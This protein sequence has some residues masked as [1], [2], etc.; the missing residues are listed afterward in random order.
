MVY[1]NEL[2]Q[3][4]RVDGPAIKHANGSQ[5]WWFNGKRHRVGGPAVIYT[6]GIEE[7]YHHGKRHRVDG[8]AM[9]L[10]N[11]SQYWYIND[12]R[13]DEFEHMMLST[14]MELA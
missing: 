4:H 2:G 8:P 1:Y 12:I 13:V 6:D 14:V 3:L 7:W 11:E 10:S 9:I 5:E